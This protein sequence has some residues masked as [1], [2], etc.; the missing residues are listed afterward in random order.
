MPMPTRALPLPGSNR[1]LL[2]VGFLGVLCSAA[3]A[4]MLPHNRAIMARDLARAFT[5]V[6]FSGDPARAE[7]ALTY[8]DGPNPDATPR[9]LTELEH[10]HAHA[11][12]FV[13][14]RLAQAYPQIIARMVRDGDAVEAHSWAHEYTVLDLPSEFRQSLEHANS[15]LQAAGAP[16]SRYFRPPYGVRAPWT[17]EQARAVGENVV[18]WS[19]P[20][21]DDWDQPGTALI[22]QRT[23]AYVKPGAIMVLHDGNEGEQCVGTPDCNRAQEIAATPILIRMLRKQQLHLATIPE[24]FEVARQPTRSVAHRP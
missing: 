4:L 6:I 9:I 13:V 11:T 21:S 7:V 8:D 1:R 22:V 19:V 23:M 24:L 12:F 18:L 16:R 14:G 5:P 10:A 17:V 3:I 15:V 2:Y 20:L